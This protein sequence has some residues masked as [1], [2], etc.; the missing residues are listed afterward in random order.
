[1]EFGCLPG[2]QRRQG[3]VQDIIPQG[4]E[5]ART[6]PVRIRVDNP[7]YAMLAG[8]AP[9]V[10]FHAG[11][12]FEALLVHKDAVVTGGDSHHIFVVREGK[13][14]R[15]KILEG[16][17]FG[18]SVAVAGNIHAGEMVVVEGNER[19]FPG[20]EVQPTPRPPNGS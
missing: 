15:E 11:D 4:N 20:Q 5:K 6:F 9:K 14:V 10:I 1:L 7:G 8:M 17:A 13:A 3:L 18:S 2:N 12:P 16:Q 19:L